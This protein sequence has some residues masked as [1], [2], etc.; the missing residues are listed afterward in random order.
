MSDIIPVSYTHLDE[1]RAANR[2]VR[3]LGLTLWGELIP[4]GL[5]DPVQ[6]RLGVCRK[7]QAEVANGYVRRAHL[8]TCRSGFSRDR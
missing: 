5:G 2:S 6:K 8:I 7:R 4:G 1:V 3:D